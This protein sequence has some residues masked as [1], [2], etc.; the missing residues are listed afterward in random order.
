[1]DTSGG[2][3]GFCKPRRQS[4]RLCVPPAQPQA[5]PHSP[6]TSINHHYHGPVYNYNGPTASVSAPNGNN[7]SAAPTIH[8]ILPSGKRGDA[9]HGFSYVIQF[10]GPED[11]ASNGTRTYGTPGPAVGTQANIKQAS[12]S[13]VL[14]T[15][16]SNSPP[17]IPRHHPKLPETPKLN[18]HAKKSQRP[19]P[20]QDTNQGISVPS[21]RFS[22][23]ARVYSSGQSGPQ[24]YIHSNRS[25]ADS[26]ATIDSDGFDPEWTTSTSHPGI[27]HTSEQ[28]FLERPYVPTEEEDALYKRLNR[29]VT[30]DH[31][32]ELLDSG[33]PFDKLSNG[34]P[35]MSVFPDS[36]CVQSSAMMPT[37]QS[38]GPPKA[39][40]VPPGPETTP[41]PATPDRPSSEGAHRTSPQSSPGPPPRNSFPDDPEW[42]HHWSPDKPT[43]ESDDSSRHT[44]PH[45]SRQSSPKAQHSRDVPC[46]PDAAQDGSRPG[47]IGGEVG[48]NDSDIVAYFK[49]WKLPEDSHISESTRT[50]GVVAVTIPELLAIL[51]TCAHLEVLD[52]VLAPLQHADDQSLL[53]GHILKELHV[54]APRL[55]RLSIRATVQFQNL[56][57]GMTLPALTELKLVAWDPDAV[58]MWDGPFGGGLNIERFLRRSNCGPNITSL[59]FVNMYIPSWEISCFLRSCPR[60]RHLNISAAIP[61]GT[62]LTDL[63]WF[64]RSVLDCVVRELQA[65]KELV[66]AKVDCCATQDLNL[67][68]RAINALF[69]KAPHLKRLDLTF[70]DTTVAC[71]EI[72]ACYEFV[73]ILREV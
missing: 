67:E 32:Y 50:L 20:P 28:P 40:T 18:R 71:R 41:D 27:R 29:K 5:P 16:P 1:M 68:R 59:E 52:I 46:N 11:T 43:L 47:P 34:D 48:I 23:S 33:L 35:T 25:E 14:C 37:Q 63:R 53:Q 45:R 51:R 44:S 38:H 17:F 12:T 19:R 26:D 8:A 72:P 31:D 30:E 54:V 58:L 49:A 66:D 13:Q 42:N 73:R 6:K 7:Y 39:P 15:E 9:G 64:R 2:G 3:L 56:F 60:L 4:L 22:H 70:M 61:D 36:S 62:P 57:D 55:R 24:P 65:C 21:V 10:G 69:T